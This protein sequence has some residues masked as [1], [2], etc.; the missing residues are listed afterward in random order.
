[1]VK[2]GV[3]LTPFLRFGSIRDVDPIPTPAPAPYL[4]NH[5][6][7][8]ACSAKLIATRADIEEH[9]RGCGREGGEGGEAVG[10]EEDVGRGEGEGG[11]EGD[12]VEGVE[13]KEEEVE[14]GEE[15]RSYA[16]AEC[17]GRAY[18][19]T[20]PQVSKHRSTHKGKK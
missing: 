19:F 15:R 10:E 4:R 13:V 18:L 14:W 8:P 11:G 3:M 17:G 1:M 6:T 20:G 2:G 7:C 5:W 16:C 12:G 9:V